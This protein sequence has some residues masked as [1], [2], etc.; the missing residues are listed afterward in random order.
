MLVSPHA[1]CTKLLG[2]FQLLQIAFLFML[3]C[4]I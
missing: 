4:V 3:I 2:K 1:I